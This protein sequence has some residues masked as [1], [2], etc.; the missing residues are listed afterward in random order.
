M[1]VDAAGRVILALDTDDAAQV[2][3]WLAQWP[4]L[5]WVKV[6]LQLFVRQ[7]PQLVRDLRERGLRVFLDLKLHDIPNTV[8]H[9]VAAAADT[10]A[11]LLTVHALGGRAMLEA[12]A[13]A[14]DRS[15]GDLRLLAVTVLTAHDD[16]AWAEL[17]MGD[18]IDR[19]VERLAELARFSGI[20][21]LVCSPLEVARLRQQHPDA[22]LVT[23]GVRLQ[24]QAAGDQRRVATPGGTLAAGADL[25]VVGRALTAAENPA[26]AW[27]DL[28]AD[29]DG[30]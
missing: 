9:A 30:S 28:V 6:G 23:P 4:E 13:D 18:S 26:Q 2:D 15:G 8:A 11:D 29:I 12:A 7:G 20:D 3:A 5:R 27:R 21:G 16:A 19:S 14:R 17:G 25:L 10:G 22:L 24:G 1:R